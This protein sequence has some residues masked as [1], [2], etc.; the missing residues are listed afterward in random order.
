MLSGCAGSP[1]TPPT[2]ARW[3]NLRLLRTRHAMLWSAHEVSPLTPTP[4]TNFLPEA[5]RAS[6]PPKTLMPPILFPTIG[7]WAVPQLAEGPAYA[8]SV[9]TGLLSCR[10]KRLPPGCTA[11]YRF[12]VDSANPLACPEPPL[13]EAES[14]LR[15]EAVFAF[16]AEITR[17]ARHCALRSTPV[18]ATAQ[19]T[20]SLSTIVAHI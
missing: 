9:S 14:K 12:A 13:L 5:Y 11:E 3:S 2:P 17:L 18:N 8:T 16:C 7:S 10:P 19:T 6:P 20:P 4:P 1:E 15:A